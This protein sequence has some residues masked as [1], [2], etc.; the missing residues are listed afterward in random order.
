MFGKEGLVSRPLIS[1]LGNETW[2]VIVV[3]AGAVGCASARELAGRGYKTLLVDRGDVATGTSSRSSRMLYSGVGYLAPNFPLWQIPFR[4][5]NML[6]RFFY[7]RNIMHC[8]AELVTDMPS[9]LTKHRFQYPFRDDDQHPH[10]LVAMGFRLM[11]TL[12]SRGVPLSFRKLSPEQAAHE[13]AMVAAL[14]G[15]LSGVGVFEEFMYF[16][17]E[18]IC[19][20]TALDAEARGASIRTYANVVGMERKSNGW[21]VC[22]QEQS[23]EMSG[24]VVVKAKAVVNAA[25]PWVDRLPGGGGR[26]GKKRVLGKKGVNVMVKLPDAWRGQG[27]EAFSSKGEP[28]YVFPWGDYHFIGPTETVVSEDPLNVRV[29]D[30]EID[31]ILSEANFLFPHLKLTR[32]D[33]RHCWCGVRPMSTL[34]GESVSLPVRAVEDESMPGLVTMTGSYIMMHRHA[35][36]LAAKSVEKI[37]GARGAAPQGMAKPCRDSWTDADVH[38][39]LESEHVVRLTDLV[40]RRMPAGLNNSLGRDRV[41]ELSLVAAKVLNWTEERRLNELTAFH[42]E[43]DTVFRRI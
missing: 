11:E 16:W 38:Q 21:E 17:P 22:L 6:K 35:G 3:G 42:Q 7:A 33:V 32:D 27:L 34:D 12:C 19:V 39:I 29:L 40:R 28:Y 24:R 31:Y 18:R 8:R 13:S 43:T 26:A 41:E 25:G 15:S 20:D 2:D 4:P 37:L 10:W 36:R 1:T 30:S 5:V 14:G 23:P 9:R